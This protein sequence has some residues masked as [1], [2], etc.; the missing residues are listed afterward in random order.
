[1]I[2]ANQACYIGITVLA[3]TLAIGCGGRE[4]TTAAPT[5]SADNAPASSQNRPENAESAPMTKPDTDAESLTNQIS[6]H[7][8]GETNI[9]AADLAVTLHDSVAVPD[10]A[11]FSVRQTSGPARERLYR[12]GVV[13][14]GQ[15]ILDQR[16]A[17]EIVVRAWQY[18]A[19]RTVSAVDFAT[20]VGFLEGFR[21]EARPL[22]DNDD[23]AFFKR[24][25]RP[26]YAKAAFLPREATI[27]G[28]P[29]VQYCNRSE[30]RVPFWITTAVIKA[31]NTLDISVEQI[32]MGG[33]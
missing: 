10:V 12:S 7:I 29:A 19:K 15:V 16:Q 11:V 33:R 17:M 22:V 4:D 28:R 3:C 5:G 31:D 9:A 13:H 26:E 2:S 27:E 20:V 25:E 1:M 6:G 23:L 30:S 14:K 32:P 8:A 18:G 24:T 21:T